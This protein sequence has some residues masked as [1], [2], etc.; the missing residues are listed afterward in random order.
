MRG[1]PPEAGSHNVVLGYLFGLRIRFVTLDGTLRDSI[2][3]ARLRR[4]SM[5]RETHGIAV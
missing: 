3:A 4:A 1:I 2:G 5:C